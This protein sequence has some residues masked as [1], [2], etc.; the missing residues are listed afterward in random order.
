VTSETRPWTGLRWV[1]LPISLDKENG[2]HVPGHLPGHGILSQQWRDL[3]RQI[4]TKQR[5]RKLDLKQQ[6]SSGTRH[7]TPLQQQLPINRCWIAK[8]RGGVA[9]LNQSLSP[10]HA[11]PCE[12]DSQ[13]QE[14]I[15]GCQR[16]D[17]AAAHY[18][19][20]CSRP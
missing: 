9:Y 18:H 17:Y 2:S 6:H 15:F 3:G 12:E 20:S 8:Q 16:R 19:L 7:A 4:H 14:E 11:V 5:V 10:V 1:F 13:S